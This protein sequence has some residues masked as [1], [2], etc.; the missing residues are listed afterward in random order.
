MTS[1]DAVY[2]D[3]LS[4]GE[5]VF[6]VT[7]PRQPRVRL[8][9]GE[10]GGDAGYAQSA[11][12]GRRPPQHIAGGR[13]WCSSHVRWNAPPGGQPGAASLGDLLGQEDPRVEH[14]PG[15]RALAARRGKLPRREQEILLLRFHGD[16][17]RAQAGQQLRIS[18]MRVSRLLAHA[19]PSPQKRERTEIPAFAQADQNS[20]LG[21]HSQR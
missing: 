4:P 8:R 11:F 14:M 5:P 7:T 19:R 20:V 13:N 2:D 6:T 21:S 9:A 17:T 10:S 18:Q 3:G 16:M 12:S 1:Y 15:M